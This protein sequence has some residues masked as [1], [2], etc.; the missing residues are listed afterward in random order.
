[1]LAQELHKLKIKKFKRKV[2]ERFKDNIWPADLA[3]MGSL[4]STNQGAKYL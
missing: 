3:E 2:Y 4:S 1:M